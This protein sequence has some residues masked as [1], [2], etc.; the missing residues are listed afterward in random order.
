M[1]GIK[2]YYIIVFTSVCAFLWMISY[3]SRSNTD[4]TAILQPFVYFFEFIE[5]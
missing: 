4:I 3:L 2:C 1:A 5:S